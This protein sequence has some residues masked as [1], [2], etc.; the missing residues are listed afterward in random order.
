[1]AD[2][3]TVTLADLTKLQEQANKPDPL[4]W[5]EVVDYA[6]AVTLVLRGLPRG[7]KLKVLR[8]A[9]KMLG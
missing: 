1:M 6:A 2:K 7:E 5:N 3:P 9:I 8:R 4:D